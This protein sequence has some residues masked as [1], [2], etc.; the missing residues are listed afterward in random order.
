MCVFFFIFLKKKC[1]IFFFFFFQAEDGIRD[2]KVT[3]VQ[4][5]ALPIYERGDEERK[6]LDVVPVGVADEEVQ[7][8]RRLQRLRE[9]QA[10]LARAGPAVE[11]DHGAVRPADFRARRVAAVARGAVAG[12][13]DRAASTPEPD[14]HDASRLPRDV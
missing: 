1:Y 10:E 6:A 14:V 11:H 13:G 9:A 3:G 7:V 5:C 4:T 12:R 8:E 2:Y